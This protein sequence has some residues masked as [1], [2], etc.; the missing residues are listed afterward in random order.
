MAAGRAARR[1]RKQC[2][3][4][5]E[6]RERAESAKEAVKTLIATK[7]NDAVGSPGTCQPASTDDVREM[8]Q[9]FEAASLFAES[10][11]ERAQAVLAAK[12]SIECLRGVEWTIELLQESGAVAALKTVRDYCKDSVV[13]SSA[14]ALVK[15]WRK[16]FKK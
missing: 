6:E 15:S 12:E 4:Y 14:K 8:L 3:R 5:E 16:A 2:E 13:A 1:K 7:V 10:T 9:P 11:L